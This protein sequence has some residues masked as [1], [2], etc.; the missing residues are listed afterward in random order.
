M[1]ETAFLVNP[2]RGD[3]RFVDDQIQLAQ[4]Q[5]LERIFD[6]EPRRARRKTAPLPVRRDDDLEL[7]AAVDVVELD[8]LDETDELA[9]GIERDEAA[10]ALV[11]HVLVVQLRQLG[12]RFVRLF[13]PVTHDLR[14]I[15]QFVDETQVLA[16][17]RPQRERVL[18]IL[19][20]HGELSLSHSGAAC[21]QYGH[22]CKR[23]VHRGMRRWKM[24]AGFDTEPKMN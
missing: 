3:I 18:F 13:E 16:L 22:P 11:V 17:E 19:D 14:V 8:Q 24:T 5:H 21:G 2:D 7:A 9:V 20:L 15:V 12:E 1:L 23:G 4:V 6:G 10:L